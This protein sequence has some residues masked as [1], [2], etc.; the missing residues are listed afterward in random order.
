MPWVD[1]KKI[2]HIPETTVTTKANRI[3]DKHLSATLGLEILKMIHTMGNY[4]DPVHYLGKWAAV[5]MDNYCQYAIGEHSLRQI[6][7]DLAAQ[8][9]EPEY[10]LSKE[11]VKLLALRLITGIDNLNTI[12]EAH[13]YGCLSNTDV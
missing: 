12:K 8:T 7:A 1:P 13:S 11:E 4:C 9:L 10:A 2:T 3:Y 5:H 6:L